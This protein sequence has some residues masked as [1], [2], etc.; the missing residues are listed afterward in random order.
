MISKK[1]V[2]I[3]GAGAHIPY[4]F[5]SGKELIRNV[6]AQLRVAQNHS[7]L[8]LR[9]LPQRSGVNSQYVQQQNIAR[10]IDSL[11]QAGQASIDTFLNANQHMGGYDVLGKVGVAQT[12]LQSEANFLT[13]KTHEKNTQYDWF[14]YLFE[15][16]ADGIGKVEHFFR[17]NHISFIT[18]N[19]DRLLE[20]KLFNSLKNSFNIASDQDV[21]NMVSAI[22]IHH[23]Y[24]SLGE[25]EPSRFGDLNQWES[26]F[27]S[28]NT[29]Y[30]VSAGQ[31]DAVNSAISALNEAEK[32]CLLG[33][34]FHHEN[35]SLL[36]LPRV[37]EEQSGNIAACRHGVTDEV[38]RRVVFSNRIRQSKLHIAPEQ[39]KA[40]ETLRNLP[41]FD[42]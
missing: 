23:V 29:I 19:Y 16:M 8:N 6:V 11:S 27:K 35:V 14:E 20:F 32:I 13:A 42:S 10:F 21:L 17:D 30:E 2:F 3:L 1:T 34:G 28:I 26:S 36:D 25:F 4:G 37:I 15:K 7:D 12:L 31:S 38:I 33:F 5:P 40:L 18:F 39:M 22:P 41:V 9:A 24:G